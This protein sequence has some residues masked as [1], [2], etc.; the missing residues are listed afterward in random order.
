MSKRNS[1]SEYRAHVFQAD[2]RLRRHAGARTG[3]NRVAVHHLK[4]QRAAFAS[5]RLQGIIT[6][7]DRLL[8]DTGQVS[9][10]ARAAGLVSGAF[11]DGGPR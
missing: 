7:A 4:G 11:L 9:R 3:T 2:P 5:G 6:R 10:P 1:T 8:R